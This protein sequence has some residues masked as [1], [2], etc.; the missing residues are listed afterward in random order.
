MAGTARR[1]GTS[2]EHGRR[3]R[4][5]DPGTRRHGSPL[6]RRAGLSIRGSSP[7]RVDATVDVSVKLGRELVAAPGAHKLWLRC[8]EEAKDAR[9]PGL[10]LP[11]QP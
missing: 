10:S 9:T 4:T 6:H 11:A 2:A 8:V 7:E 5:R 1:P 3:H